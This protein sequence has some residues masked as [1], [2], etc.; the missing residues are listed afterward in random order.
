MENVKSVVEDIKKNL[1]Q[2][3]A[4]RKDEITVMKALM[5][6]TEYTVDVYDKSGKCGEVQ[7]GK[8]LRKVV[9]AAVSATT[10]MPLKEAT[11]LVDGYEFSKVDANSMIE[12]S[13]EFVNT[14]LQ[15]GRKMPLGGRITSNIELLWRDIEE[16]STKMPN[17]ELTQASGKAG[18]TITVPAH[19]GLKVFNKC[20]KWVKK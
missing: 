11:A 7:P 13:K 14:Y 1:V 12:V 17:N 19:G 18:A 10:K 20:P 8:E 3:S 4:S 15:T 5:N 9:S 16:K 6:D 2:K